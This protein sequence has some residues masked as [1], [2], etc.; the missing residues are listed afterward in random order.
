LSL[1]M[2]WLGFHFL[3]NK[4]NHLSQTYFFSFTA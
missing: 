2:L 4:S 1:L 3:G